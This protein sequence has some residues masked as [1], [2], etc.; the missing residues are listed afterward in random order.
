MDKIQL[1]YKKSYNYDS[2]NYIEKYFKDIVTF[3]EKN[4]IRSF[5]CSSSGLSD[6]EGYTRFLTNDFKEKFLKSKIE[7]NDNT[8]EIKDFIEYIKQSTKTYECENIKKYKS[9]MFN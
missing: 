3:N 8:G 7:I 9:K 1:Y 4:V 2:Y 5:K 6:E